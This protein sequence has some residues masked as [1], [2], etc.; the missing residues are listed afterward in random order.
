M[1]PLDIID[2]DNHR[3]ETMALLQKTLLQN[4]HHVTNNTCR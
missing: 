2:S 4:T 1:S 3:N